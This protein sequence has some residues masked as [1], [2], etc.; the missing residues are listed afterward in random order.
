MKNKKFNVLVTWRLM[1]KFLKENKKQYHSNKIRFH[2]KEKKQGLVENEIYRIVDKYDAL[3]CGDDE[4]TNRV[5][6]KAK[7]LK[8]ISKWGTGLDSINVKYARKKG[9]KVFNTPNAF[10][11]GVAQLALSFILNF[12]RHTFE[13]H[14]NI[15]KGN[16]PKISGFLIKEKIIG[17]IGFGNIGREVSR[18]VLKLGMKVIYNDIK[19]IKNFNNK[20]IYKS[21]LKE[22]LKKSDIVITC[23]DLNHTS[24]N[25]INDSKMKLMKNTS[26]IINIS[27]GGIVNENDL[28]KNLNSKKIGFAALD[29][30]KKEPLNKNS[31]LLKFNNCILSSHNAFNTVEEVN[32]VSINTLKNLYKGLRI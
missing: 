17:I 10:T 23:C 15:K 5:I 22:L 4:I 12:S 28:I 16:W 21:S 20:N 29:V 11:K 2:F 32:K 7:N 9:I 25:L 8:V 13:T 1:I 3:V 30:F 24:L 14:E 27:R 19:K 31:K 18:L 26:G 6:D